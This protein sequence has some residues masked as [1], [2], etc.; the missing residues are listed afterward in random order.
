MKNNAVYKSL[1]IGTW[2]MHNKI[3]AV[4]EYHH[5]MRVSAGDGCRSLTNGHLNWKMVNQ[6]FCTQGTF[7]IGRI[8]KIKA[9]KPQSKKI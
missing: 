1:V 7:A 4:P 2:L 5:K 6:C 3:I 9:N 8:I